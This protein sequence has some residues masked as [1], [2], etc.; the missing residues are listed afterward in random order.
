MTAEHTYCLLDTLLLNI[1]LRPAASLHL[2]SHKV[3]SWP[4]LTCMCQR[5]QKPLHE[6][7]RFAL[8]HGCLNACLGAVSRLNHSAMSGAVYTIMVVYACRLKQTSGDGG[9]GSDCTGCH[10]LFCKGLGAFV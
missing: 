7:N 1:P 3:F 2:Q 6:G 8:D 9:A 4:W 10:A 5:K